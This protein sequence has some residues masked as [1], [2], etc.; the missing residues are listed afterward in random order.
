LYQAAKEYLP[1][2]KVATPRD[3]DRISQAEA[4]ND[5]M[6]RID[7]HGVAASVQAVAQYNVDKGFVQAPPDVGPAPAGRG[8]GH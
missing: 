4:R 3:A 6:G 5:P 2:D 8:R 1:V 7:P